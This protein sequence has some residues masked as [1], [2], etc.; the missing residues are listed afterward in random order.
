MRKSLM[1]LVAAGILA[2]TAAAIVAG[3]ALYN[4]NAIIARN[5]AHIL[6]L[7]SE[8]LERKVQVDQVTA[9]VG[10]GISIK[11]SRLQIA[12]DPAF[13]QLPFLTAPSATLK[14]DL[15]PILRGHVRVSALT[16]TEPDIRVL[17]DA[18]GNLNLDS[19]GGPP[20]QPGSNT[21]VPAL[22][23][24]F[25]VGSLEIEDGALHYSQNGQTAAP[26]E[27]HHLGG[28]IEDFG[29]LSSFRLD[30]KFAFT[31]E[32]P[33]FTIAGKLG[34]LLHNREFD[35]ASI[36]LGVKFTAGPLVIDQLKNVI[37]IGPA[38]PAD[39]AMPDATTFSGTLK[40]TMDSLAFDVTGDLT[41]ARVGYSSAFA[42]PAKFPMKVAAD[43]VVGLVSDNFQPGAVHLHLGGM[44]AT[45]DQISLPSSGPSQIRI[46]TNR[47]DLAQIAPTIPAIKDL[48]VTG[49][50]QAGGTLVFGTGP[51]SGNVSATL[52]GA[53][54]G[55]AGGKIPGL[56]NLDTTILLRD[57]ALVLEPATFSI[58]GGRAAM[59]GSIASFH[60]LQA[61]YQFDAETVRP[62]AFVPSRAPDEVLNKLHVA[63]TATGD[64]SAPV[65]AAR[66]TSASGLLNRAAYQ[67]LDVQGGYANDRLTANPLKV[68][69]F[70]GT[71]S[72]VGALSLGSRPQFNVTAKMNGIDLQ[73]AFEA[74]DPKTQRR[75]RGLLTGNVK[76]AGSGN[77][78]KSISP[79]LNGNG[80]LA[81]ANGKIVGMNIVAIA[82]NKIAAAPGVNQIVNAAFLSKNRG[83]LADPDTELTDARMTF[84][85]ADERVT[86]HDLT[87]RSADYGIAGDGWFDLANNISMSMDIQLTVG[88]SVT[89]PVYVKGRPPVIIVVPDIPKLAERIA[90]GAIS[91]PGRIIKGGVS[92]LNSLMG[93]G[94]SESE[95][96]S[97]PNPLEKLKGL[98]P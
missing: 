85:L 56:S 68:A 45:V 40:G 89:L 77:D 23:A 67:N 18:K 8:A 74:L 4:L 16:L 95:K 78:W 97:I 71:L 15:L 32:Q 5:Q 50:G 81:L 13:S 96:S 75:L 82:I 52:T 73:Q 31:Q 48:R 17:E 3:Y 41:P 43:G 84:V 83:V 37:A 62:A 59:Q 94:S 57:R 79:T 87:V 9:H 22:L 26:I 6:N 47:F 93:K 65:I 25:F 70:S 51:L 21:K 44:D 66:I 35:L 36:P 10:W 24:T 39:L 64:L 54:I 92:G 2:A 46:Q 76:L 86:T 20:G 30:L 69:V 53:S 28:E 55:A 29:L 42:K 58:G 12:D 33:N 63:G 98:I 91:V 60:P 1:V 80:S 27:I 11:V 34:P 61:T 7:T 88:L 38:I 72:A 49:Q 90:L 14:I 19:I